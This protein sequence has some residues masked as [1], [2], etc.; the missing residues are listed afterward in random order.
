M[1]SRIRERIV[2]C[3]GSRQVGRVLRRLIVSQSHQTKK[4]SFWWVRRSV[5]AQLPTRDNTERVL[6]NRSWKA[7]QGGP[8]SQKVDELR[9]C[10]R[11]TGHRHTSPVYPTTKK[12]SLARSRDLQS[13]QRQR[14]GARDRETDASL[15]ET[16]A[17]RAFTVLVGKCEVVGSG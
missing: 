5:Y 13:D 8:A 12:T 6:P 9:L 2:F 4:G 15:P 3:K 16:F 11:S 17:N 10:R 14:I 7:R 1:P